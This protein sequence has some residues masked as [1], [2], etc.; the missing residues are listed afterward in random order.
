ML[1]NI[2]E[3]HTLNFFLNSFSSFSS[4]FCFFGSISSLFLPLKVGRLESK[5]QRLS[6][7]PKGSI[8]NANLGSKWLRIIVRLSCLKVDVIVPAE[9]RKRRHILRVNIIVDF[10]INCWMIW[11]STWEK[12][13]M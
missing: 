3:R 4:F 11:G 12:L 13:V 8:V 2:M 5:K 1:K 9:G 10:L 6:E 7:I